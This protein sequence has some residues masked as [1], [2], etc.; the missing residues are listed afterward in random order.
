MKFCHLDELS[1]KRFAAEVANITPRPHH[2]G[3]LAATRRLLPQFAF[4]YATSRGGWHRPGGVVHA[5]GSRVSDDLEA[6][7]DTALEDCDGDWQVLLERYAEADLLATRLIGRTLYF[8][9]SY[10]EVP[11]SFLQLEIEELQEVADR[12]LIDPDRPPA[13]AMELIEPQTGPSLQRQLLGRPYYRFVRLT[14]I[15]LVLAS[16]PCL[17]GESAIARFFTEW[18]ASSAA[19]RG[20]LCA[21]WLM[22]LREHVDRYRNRRL[23][24]IPFSR[25][26]RVLKPFH[27]RPQ[28]R[29][30][31]L[32]EQLKAFDR[33]A[34]YP[35]AWYFHLVA[36]GLTPT[37]IAQAISE[38]LAAGYRYLPEPDMRLILGWLAA[39]YRL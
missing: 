7:V 35:A 4:S 5:D 24:I 3:L 10:A 25:H 14:D 15:R 18:S 23:Q 13:D 20:P 21:H 19:Q 29:G 33:A 9:A 2:T 17:N 11:A 26:A 37:E 31:E 1:L 16:D 12:P 22:D 38:D 8:V 30:V 36:E 39:P 6:W 32:A 28:A 27:W 34:G